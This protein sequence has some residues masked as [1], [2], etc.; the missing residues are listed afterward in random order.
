[1]VDGKAAVKLIGQNGKKLDRFATNLTPPMM[2]RLRTVPNY[3]QGTEEGRGRMKMT[4]SGECG[5][6]S[7]VR[8]GQSRG[9]D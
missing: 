7:H 4:I 8:E 6:I 2:A 1:V 9:A 3:H 5:D